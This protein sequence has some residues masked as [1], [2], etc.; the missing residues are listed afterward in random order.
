MEREQRLAM[1][2]AI[3]VKG[4]AK[5]F[6]I[7]EANRLCERIA[8]IV[9]GRIVQIDGVATDTMRQGRERAGGGR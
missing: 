4:L 3:I 2:D 5:R 1:Y 8:F 6:E 9:A 7:E